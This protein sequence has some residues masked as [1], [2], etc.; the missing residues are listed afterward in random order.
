MAPQKPSTDIANGTIHYAQRADN[1][2]EIEWEKHPKFKGVYLKHLIRGDDTKG[3]FSSHLVKID[4][5]CRLETHCHEN[6]MELHEVIDGTGVYQLVED[7]FDYHAGKMAL[8]PKG[9]N[10]S[11][12]A[13]AEGLTLLA[14]FFPAMG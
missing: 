5:E 14:K 3:V 11:V 13:G 8:I 4:P 7:R 12:A 1:I 2:A 10:H 6:Q 9:E